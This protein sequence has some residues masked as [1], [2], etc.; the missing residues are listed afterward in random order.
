MKYFSSFLK[1]T[2]TSALVPGVVVILALALVLSPASIHAGGA[3]T[4]KL[5]MKGLKARA[6]GEFE[7]ALVFLNQG[8]DQGDPAGCFVLGVMYLED[9]GVAVDKTK[10]RALFQLACDGK[11]AAG[12]TNLAI[13]N[14]AGD[15][16]EQDLPVA[17]ELY[18]RSCDARQAL[19]CY[20]LS[21]MVKDGVGGE[22]NSDM[23][24]ELR[25]KACTLGYTPACGSDG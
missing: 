9:N 25:L 12:C 8:C 5:T 1:L 19:A 3:T 14:E 2:I 15:G 23:G 22:S 13:M 20:K 11:N 16:G 18:T 6:N 24:H 7:N 21:V 10:A 4:S 17:R